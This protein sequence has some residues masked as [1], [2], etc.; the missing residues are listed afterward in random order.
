MRDFLW[1]GTK[2][3]HKKVE[4]NSFVKLLSN[5]NYDLPAPGTVFVASPLPV[6]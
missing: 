6:N 4:R 5:A 2:E 3:A 1:E